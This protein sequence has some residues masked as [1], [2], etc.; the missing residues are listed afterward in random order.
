MTGGL[1]SRDVGVDVGARFINKAIRAA[2]IPDPMERV[3]VVEIDE[4]GM[5]HL[6]P[7]GGTSPRRVV[8]SAPTLFATYEQEES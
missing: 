7:I 6:A 3:T 4:A 5:V 1:F 8:V 2:G